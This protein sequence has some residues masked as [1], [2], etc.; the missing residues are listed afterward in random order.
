MARYDQAVKKRCKGHDQVRVFIAGRWVRALDLGQR[1]YLL[2][3]T[4]RIKGFKRADIVNGVTLDEGDIVAEKVFM[5]VIR[6][7]RYHEP[8]VWGT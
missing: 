4:P 5:R 2:I 6:G 8:D 7:G 1:H 3:E